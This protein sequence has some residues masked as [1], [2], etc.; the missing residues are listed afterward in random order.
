MILLVRRKY[1]TVVSIF[2]LWNVLITV[3]KAQ[4]P[5]GA[6]QKA[7]TAG[8]VYGKIIDAKTGKPVE[9]AAVQLSKMKMDSISNSQKET[10]LN[11]QLTEGNGDFSLEGV[12]VLGEM[13]FKVSAMGYKPYE[14]KVSFNIQRGN[15]QQALNAVDKD[16]GNIKIEPSLVDLQEVTIDGTAPILE[17]RPDK[18]VYNV[19]KNPI[20]TG[21]T[22]EDVLKNVPSVNVDIDGNVTMRNAAPQIFVDGRPTTLTVDQIPADAIQ[23][24]ELITNPSAK[25]DASGGMAGIL[26]IVLKKNKRVGYNGTVRTGVDSRGRI[27]AGADLNVREGKVNWFVNGNL[28]QR[29]SMGTGITERNNFAQTPQTEF[30][31]NTT[32]KNKGYFGLIRSGFDIFLDNRNTFTISGSYNR[33]KFNP[34]DELKTTTDTILQSGIASGFSTRNSDN[35]RT[36]TNSGGTIAFK[37]LFPKEGKEI[38]AD[39]N[40]NSMKSNQEGNYMTQYFNSENIPVSNPALQQQFSNGENT[41]ITLQTDFVTPL[42]NKMKVE[43]GLRGAI[44]NYSSVNQ[45]FIFNDSAQNYLLI[46]DLTANYKF[47]DQVYAAYMTFSQQINKLSYQAGARVESSFYDG[48]LTQTGQKF[49]NNFPVSLFPSASLSYKINEKNDLNLIYSRK[50][51]RPT[52]FQLIPF[53]DYS[54]SLNLSKG[55]PDLTPEFTNSVEMSW[56]KTF[57]RK[58]TLLASIYFKRTDDVI[59][60]YI[61]YQYDS[62]IDKSALVSTFL[63]ANSSYAY[64]VEL[65]SQ[66]NYGG[67]LD[68]TA[69]INAYQSVIDGKNIESNLSNEQFSW[70]AKLNLSFKLP[71]NFSASVSGDYQSRTALQLNSS[72]GGRGGMG[73]GGGPMGGTQTTAQGYMRENYGVDAGLKYEFWKDKAGS[74][75]FNVSDIFKTK[76]SDSYSE[77]AFYTQN[78]LRKRDA[79]IMRL[80]F[81]YRFGK[82]DTSLFKRKNN[83][84]N[85]DSNPDMGM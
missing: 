69:N 7:M 77:S 76:K 59:T 26:N 1:T 60:R 83:K 82:F 20:A 54:D 49:T 71:K 45:N 61:S 56:L 42:K 63:N 64:G 22:A 43:A 80:T 57:S 16:L 75:T 65:T 2:F 5:Q 79:Q 14:Q 28:N 44:R 18:K 74:L 52:F 67:W 68:V 70:F 13:T 78:S 10:I 32:S 37:H 66:N 21:G 17:L 9:F 34:V 46:P 24:I 4:M 73:G 25:Y 72:G 6:M 47:T 30:T 55:N 3:S 23:E 27:N 58:N 51:N 12:P 33:G 85:T 31:Q 8:H 84:V 11:G 38:T 41:F 48:E 35:E 53:T 81:S 62:I 40:F 15:M 50:I 36:Y 39:A 19:E 29:R